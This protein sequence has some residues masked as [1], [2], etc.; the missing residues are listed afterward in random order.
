[1]EIICSCNGK[2]FKRL[3][4]CLIFLNLF[5][6]DSIFNTMNIAYIFYY[7]SKCSVSGNWNA[8]ALKIAYCKYETYSK[9]MRNVLY[10]NIKLLYLND[11][12]YML[13]DF[14]YY[15]VIFTSDRKWTTSKTVGFTIY[16]RLKNTKF[17][18]HCQWFRKLIY[19]N[20]T[21]ISSMILIETF[22]IYWMCSFFIVFFFSTM[23]IKMTTPVHVSRTNPNLN[24]LTSCSSNVH[25]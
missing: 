21:W 10:I 13:F 12:K 6:T 16:F 9:F 22:V 25:F 15:K 14:F 17:S 18:D 4:K 2:Q 19:F 24:S 3:L 23:N 1:M 8:D 5:S 11:M 7:F 20:V